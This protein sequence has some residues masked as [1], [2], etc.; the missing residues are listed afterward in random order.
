MVSPAKVFYENSAAMLILL[1]TRPHPLTRLEVVRA[2]KDKNTGQ[3]YHVKGDTFLPISVMSG[4]AVGVFRR[5][6]V[7]A[8]RWTELECAIAVLAAAQAALEDRPLKYCS[9]RTVD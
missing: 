4:N 5:K 6:L 3:I 2:S 1:R 9:L 8:V 7:R